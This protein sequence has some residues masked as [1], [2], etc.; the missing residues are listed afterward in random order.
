VKITLDKSGFWL[1]EDYTF[2]RGIGLIKII[3][4]K[5]RV[6]NP[7]NKHGSNMKERM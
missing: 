4:A 1:A 2:Y 6:E 5:K 7:G 3:N